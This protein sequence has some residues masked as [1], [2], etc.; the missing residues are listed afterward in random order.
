MNIFISEP[1]HKEVVCERSE[2]AG[3]LSQ[4]LVSDH[5]KSNDAEQ[6]E[7]SISPLIDTRQNTKSDISHSSSN[8][9]QR[10]NGNKGRKP[11]LPD[12]IQAHSY[13][14]PSTKLRIFSEDDDQLPVAFNTD[15]DS[16]VSQT[17]DRH[18]TKRNAL[19][20]RSE[21][22]ATP[23]NEY[24][25]IPYQANASSAPFNTGERQK[26]IKA[27]KPF[28]Y[29]DVALVS[30]ADDTEER[31]VKPKLFSS[32]PRLHSGTEKYDDE[33][34]GSH[35]SQTNEQHNRRRKPKRSVS[36]FKFDDTTTVTLQKTDIVMLKIN[37]FTRKCGD[38]KVSL[39]EKECRVEFNGGDESI[40][41]AK[42]KMYETL[43]NVEEI[44]KVL[45]RHLVEYI[46]RSQ[47]YLRA[48]LTKR[49]IGAA[50]KI[51]VS[52]SSVHCLA[53]TAKQAERGLDFVTKELSSK[54][55]KIREGQSQCFEN[56]EWDNLGKSFQKQVQVTVV[57]EDDVVDI[58][59][60]NE[61]SV[62]MAY[63]KIIQYLKESKP[64]HKTEIELKG[65]TARCFRRHFLHDLQQT[66]R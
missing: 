28:C 39:V 32:Q 59:A 42:I 65:A 26:P 56:A 33:P 47:G 52:Q 64:K 2:R 27:V 54:Q 3:N 7:F 31:I 34:Q 14:K 16:R 29:P 19:F 46:D 62:N 5:P 23:L 41:Q 13:H 63:R 36:D 53:F 4:E 40:N 55:I 9:E 11:T 8:L 38:C 50:L 6:L 60:Y 61:D 17:L 21:E 15:H 35:E 25:N 10:P 51:D 24:T 30:L 20:S 43:Q 57:K 66:I 18:S 44:S 12:N 1:K 45:P 37:G 48:Q 49:K 58:V 22:V